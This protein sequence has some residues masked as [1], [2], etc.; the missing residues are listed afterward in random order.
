MILQSINKPAARV[1]APVAAALVSPVFEITPSRRRL[2]I[3]RV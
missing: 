1:N 2:Y 3:S